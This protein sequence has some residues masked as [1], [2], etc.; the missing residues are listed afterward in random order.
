MSRYSLFTDASF[1][2]I[3]KIGVVAI[4]VIDN[5]TNERNIYL[6]NNDELKNTQLELYGIDLCLA[7]IG[8]S[9]SATIYT[10]CQAWVKKEIPPNYQVVKI[11]A[12]KKKSE[13]DNI[14]LEF[15]EVDILS[16]KLLRSR[17]KSFNSIHK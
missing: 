12:H 3:V 11:K 10:D 7:L 1:N 13:C 2:H 4:K 8:Y 14:E 9:E 15:R 6:F 16:R 17:I 5:L